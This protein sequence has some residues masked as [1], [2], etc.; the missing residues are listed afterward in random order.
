MTIRAE[1]RAAAGQIPLFAKLSTRTSAR[2]FRAA[3]AH[4]FGTGSV[5]F[6]EGDAAEHFHVALDGYVCLKA[7]DGRGEDHVI[8]FVR[9]GT[10]FIAAAV[11][12]GRPFLLTAQVVQPG[13]ILFI[14]ADDFRQAAESD[15][16]LAVALIRASS[17]HW[18]S[19]IGQLKSLKMQTATQR[20]ASFLLSLAEGQ[21]EPATIELPCERRLL[22]TW[23]GMV[24]TS[25][26]RAFGELEKIGVVG[27][28][29]RLQI[30]SLEQLAGYARGVPFG[31]TST[32]SRAARR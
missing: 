11:M 13:R 4:H 9:P 23:L 26:S 1:D 29:S 17:Q 14:P 28:G 24:P 16:A 31:K 2:L 3:Q 15:L 10:A 32:A 8:E 20:L 19:M 6:R 22:A 21:G 25:A 18:R 5:L 7:S 12:L 27:H 30:R